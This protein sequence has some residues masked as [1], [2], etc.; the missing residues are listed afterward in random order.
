MTTDTTSLP[1]KIFAAPR[2]RFP[3]LLPSLRRMRTLAVTWRQRSRERRELANLSAFDLKDLGYP[4]RA[5]A[6]KY[7]S[8]WQP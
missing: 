3:S 8:F 1:A 2:F 6:E 4:A 7:K 5:A